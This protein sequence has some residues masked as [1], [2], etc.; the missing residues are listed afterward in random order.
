MQS[1]LLV[2]TLI[3]NKNIT[4][5]VIEATNTKKELVCFLYSTCYYPIKSK[6]IKATQNSNF[7]TFPVLTAELVNKYLDIE[8]PTILGHLHQYK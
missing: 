2:R 4:A 7:A 3:S 8:I 6:W 5:A 1:K